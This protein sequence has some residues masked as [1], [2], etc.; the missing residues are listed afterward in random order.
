MTDSPAM[1]PLLDPKEQS[2]L[3]NLT[4]LRDELELLKQNRSAYIQ[5][6]VVNKSLEFLIHQ[7]HALSEIRKEDGKAHTKNEVDTILED[8]FQLI[9]LAFMTIG[10]NNEAPATYAISSIMKRLLD[11]LTQAGFYSYKDLMSMERQIQVIHECIKRGEDKYSPQII[12]LLSSRM[13]Y[14][15]GVLNDLKSRIPKSCQAL[16]PEYE[17]LVSILRSLAAAN[18]RSCVSGLGPLLKLLKLIRGL[19]P[20]S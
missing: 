18:T 2:I 13:E 20:R 3:D 6:D 19:V 11:H 16:S 5:S 4:A 8:C 12:T 10:R 14:S 15:Q 9:S 17:K 7:V 1:R